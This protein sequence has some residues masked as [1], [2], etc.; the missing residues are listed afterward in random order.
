MNVYYMYSIKFKN[1]NGYTHAYVNVC[2]HVC[3]NHTEYLEGSVSGVRPSFQLLVA[4]MCMTC[5]TVC[6]YMQKTSINSHHALTFSTFFLA[7][8]DFLFFF[9]TSLNEQSDGSFKSG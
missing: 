8:H 1:L 9:L 6:I 5:V 4:C 7:L 3:T 2:I